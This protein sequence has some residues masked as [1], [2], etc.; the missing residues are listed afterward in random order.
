MS[1]GEH[2]ILSHQ[3]RHQVALPPNYQYTPISLHVPPSKPAKTYPFELDP[4]QKVAIAS[5]ERS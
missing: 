3:V 2:V 1:E 4:F 5:I